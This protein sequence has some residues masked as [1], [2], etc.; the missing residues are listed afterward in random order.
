MAL[1]YI[2]LQAMRSGAGSD[3]TVYRSVPAATITAAS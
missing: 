2:A 1:P 3:T